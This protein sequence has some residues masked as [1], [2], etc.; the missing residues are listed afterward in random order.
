MIHLPAREVLGTHWLSADCDWII[1]RRIYREI[2]LSL[3]EQFPD[4]IDERVV[5]KEHGVVRCLRNSEH[6]TADPHVHAVMETLPPVLTGAPVHDLLCVV[7]GQNV[8]RVFLTDEIPATDV[9]R[10]GTRIWD[11]PV[12]ERSCSYIAISVAQELS[13]P[14]DG[15]CGIRHRFIQTGVPVW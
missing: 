2:S 14:H 9:S 11:V 13:R 1:G 7:S 12:G 10:Q 4:V 8:G 15:L 5:H 6:V 3:A